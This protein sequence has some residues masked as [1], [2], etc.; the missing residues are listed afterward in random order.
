VSAPQPATRE[1]LGLLAAMRPDWEYCDVREALAAAH[2]AARPW[3]QV[4]VE[5][6]RLAADPD[7]GPHDLTLNAPDAWRQR[8]QPQPADTAHRGAALARAAVHRTHPPE[9]DAG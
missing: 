6:V 2:A 8:R 7:A 9:G 4:A 3:P 1:L 5:I